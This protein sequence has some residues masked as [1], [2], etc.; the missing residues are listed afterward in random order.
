MEGE[1]AARAERRSRMK[2]L[3]SSSR[4]LSAE[5][6][7]GRWICSKCAYQCGSEAALQNHVSAHTRTTTVCDYCGKTTDVETQ[8]KKV[9]KRVVI[10]HRENKVVVEY[11]RVPIEIG[12]VCNERIKKRPVDDDGYRSSKK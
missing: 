11:D 8:R 9:V 10:D 2:A 1:A 6:N 12:H 7:D 4:R 5:R 3:M